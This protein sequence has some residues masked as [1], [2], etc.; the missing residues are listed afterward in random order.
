MPGTR[1]GEW[2]PGSRVAPV[3]M[4]A[5]SSP[6]NPYI[7]LL[8][9]ALESSGTPVLPIGEHVRFFRTVLRRRP[10]AA[11]HIHWLSWL[12]A[13]LGWLRALSRSVTFLF[14][15][16]LL[17]IVGVRVVW[18]VHNLIS[19]DAR[20]PGLEKCVRMTL[21][22]LSTALVVHCERAAREIRDLLH[23]TRGSG[24]LVVIPHGNYVDWYPQLEEPKAARLALGLK[25][26]VFTIVFLGKVRRYKGLEDLIRAYEVL[27]REREVQLVVA[28]EVLEPE[29]GRELE[30][31]LT[32]LPAVRWMPGFVDDEIVGRLMASADVVAAPY[33]KVLTS[34][35]VVLAM[36]LG[37]PVV[38]PAAG[39]IP[40]LLGDGGG[41]LYDAA[42]PAGLLGALE[43]AV[44]SR[45]MLAEM[46]ARNL[47]RVRMLAWNRIAGATRELYGA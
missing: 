31:S 35:T 33:R 15:L 41:F 30:K 17:R 1:K 2:G 25:P 40:E 3:V 16:L 47:E 20:Y 44:D 46:G 29:Y 6:E 28:G 5:R 10:A 26:G 38:A 27:S 45:D 4:L 37:R 24:K 11:V 7:T 34:G 19:H 13:D 22:R 36:S 9:E 39:C 14:Q 42:D 23:I 12:F 18:T 43:T 8:V 32:E 21:A